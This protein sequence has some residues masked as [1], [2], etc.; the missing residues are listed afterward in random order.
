MYNGDETGFF[1]RSML[2][3]NQMRKGDK[4]FRDKKSSKKSFSVFVC[5][6][7]SGTYGLKL[8][9]VNKSKAPRALRAIMSDLL[10]HYFALAK[11]YFTAGVFFECFQKYFVPAVREYK[12][13]SLK[14]VPENVKALLILDKAPA[15]LSESVSFS[16]DGRISVK[17]LSPNTT[18]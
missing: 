6:N 7:A 14:I 16:D 9:I 12:I 17:F 10:A 5:A 1:W 11:A 2:M 18:S 3:N 15:H 8:A 13:H 4:T